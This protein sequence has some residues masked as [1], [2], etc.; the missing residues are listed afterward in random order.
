MDAEEQ[1]ALEL[2]ERAAIMRLPSSCAAPAAKRP[3]GLDT[4]QRLPTKCRVNW[5]AMRWTE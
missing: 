4:S 5:L 2:Q 1:V 3:W